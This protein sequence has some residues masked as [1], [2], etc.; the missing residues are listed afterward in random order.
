[1]PE[2]PVFW[3]FYE[4]RRRRSEVNS[5]TDSSVQRESNIRMISLIEH[6]YPVIYGDDDSVFI[7]VPPEEPVGH[8]NP[9]NMEPALEDMP[10]LIDFPEQPIFGISRSVQLPISMEMM[11]LI[12]DNGIGPLGGFIIE[13]PATVLPDLM[14]TS[15]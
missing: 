7:Q 12:I 2:D 5:P 4:H 13:I 10:P 3:D 15:E 9:L 6:N 8:I 11:Q 1:M 14:D